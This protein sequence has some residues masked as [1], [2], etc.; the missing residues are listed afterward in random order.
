VDENCKFRRIII[1]INSF[2]PFPYD[3]NALYIKRGKK[4]LY[5]K[6]ITIGESFVADAQVFRIAYLMGAA[7]FVRESFL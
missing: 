4:V 7:R 3:R 6:K 5:E 1:D 2:V